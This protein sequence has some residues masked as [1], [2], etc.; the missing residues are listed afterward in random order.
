MLKTFILS[1]N[2]HKSCVLD[3][4]LCYSPLS[5]LIEN[6]CSVQP[7]AIKLI[8]HEVKFFFFGSVKDLFPKLKRYIIMSEDLEE[9]M[10]RLL[11][12]ILVNLVI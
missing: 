2:T 12:V 1:I 5:V 11:T 9:H 7:V 8:Q 4:L 3:R 10:F 6:L